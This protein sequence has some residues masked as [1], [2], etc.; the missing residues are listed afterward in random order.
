MK[1]T[2]IIAVLSCLIN[3][4]YSQ[5]VI[6]KQDVN[7]DF[8]NDEYGPNKKRYRSTFTSFGFLFGN[9]DSIGSEIN[10]YKSFFYE[11]G[12]RKKRQLS[13]FYAIGRETSLNIKS[14]S[15][16]Q[17]DEKTFG[18]FE[19]HKAERLLLV[20]LNLTIYNRFNFKPNRGNSLGKYLD[21]A[22]YI[23]YAFIGR[24]IV[25]DKIDQV[26]GY[27]QG[28]YWLRGLKYL[29]KFNYGAQARFGLS[30]FSFF[31]SYRFSN[32]FKEKNQI[33]YIELPRFTAGF[34]VDMPLKRIR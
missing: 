13:K 25:T 27:S 3:T 29:N 12:N 17:H 34:S 10:W 8:E 22:G 32:L 33:D 7:K 30:H 19:K 31:C 26:S 18:G 6:L 9:P 28:K 15:I 24:H 21:L 16:K 20:N 4:V 11:T 1:R 2:F 23:E 5:N 14:Y